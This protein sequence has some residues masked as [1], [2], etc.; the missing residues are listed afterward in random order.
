MFRF[1]VLLARVMTQANEDDTT[2]AAADRRWS[3]HRTPD[4]GEPS[5]TAAPG[6]AAHARA[7]RARALRH[8]AGRPGDAGAARRDDTRRTGRT[9]EGSAAFHDP[10]DRRPGGLAARGPGAPPHRPAPGDTHRDPGRPGP[11][12][13]DAP[14]QGS[15]AGEAAGGADPRGA[16]DLAGRRAD[17]GEA[18][19]I[20]T[21]RPRHFL[22]ARP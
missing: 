4:L 11:G 19:P 10:R 15:L 6:R 5:G 14:A 21:A 3:G 7:G 18:Q 16:S 20:L 1:R 12:T 8:P 17:P 22:T 2:T 13:E 9:R